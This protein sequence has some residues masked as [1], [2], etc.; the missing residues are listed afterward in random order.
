MTTK[1]NIPD[2]HVYWL[3]TLGGDNHLVSFYEVV[4]DKA[5]NSDEINDLLLISLET[6]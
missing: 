2:K 4:C 1:V 3:G 5:M 6:A